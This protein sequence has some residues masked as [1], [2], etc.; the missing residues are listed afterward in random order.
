MIEEEKRILLADLCARLPYEVICHTSKGDGH[1]CSI[2]QTLFGTEYGINISSVKRDYFND[3]EAEEQIIKPYL[4]PMSN[5]TEEEKRTFNIVRN[6][7]TY[8]VDDWL[9]AKHFD[10]HELIFLGLALEA[11]EGM[12]K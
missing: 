11:P 9:N 6:Y 12:Y 4:R 8:G 7:N 2:N 10:Y 5:M 1:L 3:N